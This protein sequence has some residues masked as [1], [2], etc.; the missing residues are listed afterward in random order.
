MNQWTYE[1]LYTQIFTGGYSTSRVD[2]LGVPG[3]FHVD[4]PTALKTNNGYQWVATTNIAATWNKELCYKQG[5]A[6]GNEALMSNTQGWYAPG[7][8]LHRTPFGGRNFEYY[9]EDGVQVGKIAA[10]VVRG[11][12]SKGIVAF[13]KHF[14]VNNQ[15]SYRG[16]SNGSNE[17]CEAGLFTYL[18]EQNMR[19]N[20]FKAFQLCIEEGGAM[21]MM[22]SMNCIGNVGT[23]NNYQLVT[24]VV[25]QEW[26]MY[27]DVTTDIFYQ[28]SESDD[29]IYSNLNLCLRAG[30]S[31]TLI[32]GTKTLERN[33]WSAADNTV[34]VDG[35][36]K[37]DISWLSA[38][39]GAMY[40]MYAMANSNVTK[41]GI[42]LSE[43]ADKTLSDALIGMDYSA[44]I[45][46]GSSDNGSASAGDSSASGEA[47]GGFFGG[48]SGEAADAVSDGRYYTVVGGAL[49]EGMTLSKSGKLS[50]TCYRSGTYNFTVEL[51]QDGWVTSN[52]AFSLE[53]VNDLFEFSAAG[54]RCLDENAA[55]TYALDEGSALPAG[56]ALQP[57]GT[58]TGS[59]AP[60]TYEFTVAADLNG[61]TYHAADSITVGDGAAQPETS[62]AQTEAGASSG[63]GLAVAGV[64]LGA[65]GIVGAAAAILLSILR[66]KSV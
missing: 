9:G 22:V 4:G 54:V 23:V 20:Y 31:D 33:A 25:R 58:I 46:L 19:Q 56:L 55:V 30:L 63:N 52:A 6:I 37:N 5:L 59:A 26:G 44:D 21:G 11:C 62:G 2:R 61:V 18:T 27:G 32:D 12:Q 53:V 34:L 39:L 47:S 51:R 15:D 17:Q 45:S 10:E 24:G 16:N 35:A 29:T 57:D 43:F 1:E 28:V 60:G 3:T 7:L 41:N 65:I 13:V 42:D 48:A 36:K 66:K 50:G 49:P 38:R 64:V 40:A 14:A 8:N